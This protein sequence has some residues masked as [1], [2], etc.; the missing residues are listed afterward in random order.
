M[1]APSFDFKKMVVFSLRAGA[2]MWPTGLPGFVFEGVDIFSNKGD[3]RHGGRNQKPGCKNIQP[4][5]NFGTDKNPWTM[6][7]KQAVREFYFEIHLSDKYVISDVK[8]YTGMLEAE[9]EVGKRAAEVSKEVQRPCRGF[10]IIDLRR[11]GRIN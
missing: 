1:G 5:T 8:K 2:A 3:G 11:V 7:R 10:L 4:A 9:R 6:S